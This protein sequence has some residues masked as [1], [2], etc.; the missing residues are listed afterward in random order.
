MDINDIIS[1]YAISVTVDNV[2]ILYRASND[3]NTANNIYDEYY[4]YITGVYDKDKYHIIV[5]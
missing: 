3:E 4:K 1:R 5:K 2:E